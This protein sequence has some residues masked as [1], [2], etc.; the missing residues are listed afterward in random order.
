MTKNLREH[1]KKLAREAIFSAAIELFMEKGFEATKVD[2]IAKKA[3]VARR[4]F[5]R[6]FNTKEEV[7]VAWMDTASLQIQEKLIEN[8][9]TKTPFTALKLAILSQVKS[10]VADRD[11]A[12]VMSRLINETPSIR[13]LQAD[14]HTRWEKSF[15]EIIAKKST[16]AKNPLKARIIAAR[17]IDALSIAGE[18]WIESSFKADFMGILKKTFRSSES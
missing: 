14:K 15:A 4:T 7:V 17:A 3:S 1:K 2:E 16:S 10:F 12:M 8:L 11:Q 6:Y 5:F 13:L 18:A 9:K